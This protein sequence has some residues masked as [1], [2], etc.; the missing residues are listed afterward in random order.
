MTLTEIKDA[1]L[2]FG[3]TAEADIQAEFSSLVLFIEGKEYAKKVDN[4]AKIAEAISF[5]QLNGYV[6]S[7]VSTDSS[8]GEEVNIPV[9]PTGS[10]QGVVVSS[11]ANV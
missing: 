4:E 7:I 2:E 1:L 5:L 11:G 9:A 3:K 10:V 8:A 6:V